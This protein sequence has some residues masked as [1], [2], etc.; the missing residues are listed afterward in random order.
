M[1]ASSL[2]A[3]RTNQFWVEEVLK[4]RKEEEK[5]RMKKMLMV[6]EFVAN[7]AYQHKHVTAPHSGGPVMSW[8]SFTNTRNGNF[9]VIE[10]TV[11]TSVCQSTQE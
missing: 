8:A 7:P 9:A 6:L 1:K 2:G 10:L 4:T 11:N 3:F 5:Q